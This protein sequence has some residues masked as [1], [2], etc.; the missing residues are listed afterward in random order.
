MKLEIRNLTKAFGGLRAIDDVSLDFPSASGLKEAA[1][2][3]GIAGL[4]E[5]HR[6]SF[7]C[8]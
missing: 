5:R 4:T 8:R 3:C 2:K 1:L 7:G 6:S